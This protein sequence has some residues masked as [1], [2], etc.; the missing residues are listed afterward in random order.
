MS[1]QVPFFS[2]LFA[3][4][5]VFFVWSCYL[6]FSLVLLGKP[7]DRFSDFSRR[8]ANMLLYAF[9]QKRVVTRSYPFGLNHSIF[10][11]CFLILLIANTEFLLHSLCPGYIA[12]SRLP[13]GLYFALAL[14]FDIVSLVALLAVIVAISRRLFFPPKYIDARTVDAFV[15]LGLVAAL[16]LAFFGLHGSEIALGSEGAAAFMPVANFVGNFILAGAPENVLVALVQVFFWMH[17]VTLLLF[18]DYLPYSK[19]M[20]ILT[21]IPNCFFRSLEKINTQLPEEFEKGNSYGV[22]QVDQFRWKDLFDSMSC[23][24]CGRCNDNCPATVT[25]KALNPRLLI[26]DIKMNLLHNGKLLNK[27]MAPDLPLIGGDKEGSIAEA[28]LWDCTTCGACMEVCPV[29]IEHVPK[30]VY[31]RRNLVEM[32]AEFPGE[33]LTLFDNME[34]RSNPWGII[35]AERGRWTSETVAP[36][37]DREKTEYLFYVGCAGAFDTRNKRNTLAITRILNKSGVSWGALGKDET[38]CGDSLRRLGNEFVF[39]QMAK[40]NVK[41]FKQMGIKKVI[42]QCPHCYNTLKNDYRQF[43]SELEVLHYTELALQLVHSGKLTF[44]NKAEPGKVVFHDSCYLGRY[45]SIYKTPRELIE[46]ATGHAPLEME[47]SL[48]RSFC[49]GAG[50]GRMWM[51]ENM[52][53]RINLERVNE[54]LKKEP[55][56]ICVCCPYCVTMMEDG[57]MDLKVSEQVKVLELSEIIEKALQ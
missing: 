38:C 26:H 28:A 12:L 50:G 11:W 48:E 29:F 49:C 21:S 10:F 14:I 42:T 19:H 35:P 32:K 33:L 36:V 27:G 23:T 7:D 16:M 39:A 31:M 8:L 17:A 15:V 52:G 56:A 2:T 55:D 6:R 45:N 37:F 34:N 4:A 9:G 5:A 1:A 20:H 18:L 53:K 3:V 54:A 24:E 13:E 40:E 41:A 57:L 30:I 43:G 47:R 46:L 44:K 51:D 22:G 25:G